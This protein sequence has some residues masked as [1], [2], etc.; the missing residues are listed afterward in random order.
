[1]HGTG[2]KPPCHAPLPQVLWHQ[3]VILS[4]SFDP[5]EADM[6]DSEGKLERRQILLGWTFVVSSLIFILSLILVAYFWFT[7]KTEGALAASEVN[8]VVP[9][10]ALLLSVSSLIGFVLTSVLSIR[11]EQRET[12]TFRLDLE[13]KALEIE[14]LRIELA[15]AREEFSTNQGKQLQANEPLQRIA[16]KP[17]SR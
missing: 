13:K 4:V 12:Q 9:L 11:K 2:D 6:R 3:L 8:I 14:Q 17:G 16:D 10:L 7:Y 5:R 1:M 15:K